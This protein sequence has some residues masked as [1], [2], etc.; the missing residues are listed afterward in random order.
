MLLVL[1]LVFGVEFLFLIE[2][3]LNQVDNSRFDTEP[4]G[5]FE[6]R[7]IFRLGV[8]FLLNRARNRWRNKEERHRDM[9]RDAAVVNKQLI[10]KLTSLLIFSHL[11]GLAQAGS[12]LDVIKSAAP[13]IQ[14]LHLH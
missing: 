7:K 10:T 14:H 5:Q 9:V 4:V 2:A 3:G 11:Q 8:Y 6:Q 1:L 13:E 12:R